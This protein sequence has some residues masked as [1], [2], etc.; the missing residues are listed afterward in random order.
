LVQY[1]RYIRDVSHGDF[2]ESF[3]NY[4]G[5]TVSELLKKKMW[6]SAQLNIAALLISVGLGVP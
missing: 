3:P 5:R 2:G 1:G 4:R 6:V